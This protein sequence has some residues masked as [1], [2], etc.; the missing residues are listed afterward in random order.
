VNCIFISDLHGK[1]PRYERLFQII[2]QE[3]PDAVFF[4][5]D[6]L[7]HQLP[8]NYSMKEF[9]EQIIFSH[10]KQIRSET[11]NKT[12]FFI[13]L[14]NDDPR[15]FEETFIKADKK[16]VLQYIHNKTITYETLH[17]TGYAYVPPTPFLLKDWERYDISQYVDVG[18]VSPEKGTRTIEVPLDEIQ[19]TTMAED[20]ETL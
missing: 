10:I 12:Q 11:K 9:I 14:G 13:I 1:I 6:L 17:V 15:L 7:P 16:G 8:P 19:Y 3:K 4:G 20:L 5:G 18:A 2:R